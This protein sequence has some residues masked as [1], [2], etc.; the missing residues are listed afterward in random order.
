MEVLAA[1]SKDGC[2]AALSCFSPIREVHS[3]T[4]KRYSEKLKAQL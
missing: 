3:T 1:I 2:L 4:K